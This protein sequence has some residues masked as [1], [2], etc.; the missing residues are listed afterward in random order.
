MCV[1]AGELGVEDTYNTNVPTVAVKL[2]YPVV[3]IAAGLTFT[4]A[5]VNNGSVYCWGASLPRL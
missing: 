1:L 2:P 5:A 4:C 3:A